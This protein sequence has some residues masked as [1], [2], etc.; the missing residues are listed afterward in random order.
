MIFTS[1]VQL[2]P[3]VLRDDLTI[4]QFILDSQHPLRPQRGNNRPWL[5]DYPTGRQYDAEEVRNR[6]FGLSNSLYNAYGIREND[7]VIIFSP[8]DIDFPIAVWAVHRVGA[9]AS[10]S[11]PAYTEFELAHQ[12]NETKASLII[13]HPGC[14]AATKAAAAKFNFPLDRIVVISPPSRPFHT[15]SHEFRSLKLSPSEYTIDNFVTLD[16]LIDKGLTEYNVEGK[17]FPER[18][19]AK[20]EAKTKL[21]FLSFSSGTTGKPKAVA[22]SHYSLISNVIMTAT[23]LRIND[24]TFPWEDRRMRDGDVSLGVLPM[25]HIYGL[26]VVLHYN[27]FFGLPL[28]VLPKYT[29]TDF[30]T[31]IVKYRIT[32]L[33]IVPPQMV[34]LVKSPETKKYSLRHVRMVMGGAAPIS[35]DVE[36]K[37]RKILPNANVGQAYGMTETPA[38]ITMWPLEQNKGGTPGSAGR[39]LPG[40]KAK[41]VKSDGTLAGYGEPGELV[42]HGPSMALRYENNPK[43]SAETFVDG[44]VH[45]GDEVLFHENGDMFIVD[46]IKE[47]I[48]VKGFQVAPA[49]LE[50]HLLSHPAVSDAG[51]IGYPDEYSGELPMAFVVL[52]SSAA[53]RALRTPRDTERYKKEIAKHVSDHKVRYKWLDGGIEFVRTI[54]KNPSGKILRRVLR[55][56]AKAIKEKNKAQPTVNPKL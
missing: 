11:N 40:L 27:I 18:R 24:P 3:G 31:S 22:I 38:T 51:V 26:V 13:T 12:V 52:H 35:N 41:V 19:L 54:P 14:F 15:E 4:P 43:A 5:I 16:A 45:T 25:F 42:V 32:H 53:R 28:V 6:V 9:I 55:D 21:A 46:R 36:A 8:N 33:W 34:S 37:L 20:G 56:Q 30:L 49:E 1:N 44:W 50:G 2:P 29:F 23:Y 7:V 48:K 10:C 39:L 47:I 17:V